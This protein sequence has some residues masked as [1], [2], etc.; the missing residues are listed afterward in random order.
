MKKSSLITVVLLIAVTAISVELSMA[1]ETKL[2]VS[3]DGNDAWSG[4]L[5]APNPDKTDGPFATL[6]GAR[7]AVRDLKVYNKLSSPVTVYI[8][9]GKYNLKR[10]FVL[11]A[12][13]SGTKE[14]PIIYSALADEEVIITGSKR[15]S[16][17][18]KTYRDNIM[19]CTIKDTQFEGLNFRQLFVNGERQIRARTP[20]E[21]FYHVNEIIPGEQSNS[22]FKY[23]KGDLKRWRNLTDVELIIFHSWDESRINIADINEEKNV[24]HLEYASHYPFDRWSG[25]YDGVLARYFVENVLEGLDSPGEWYFD[26]HSRELYY[27]PKAGENIHDLEITIPVINQLLLF[28]GDTLSGTPVSYISFSGITFAE[29]DCP[30]GWEGRWGDQVSPAGITFS[31]ASNCRLDK[32][33]VTNTGTYGIEILNGS[34]YNTIDKTEVSYTG[35]GGI[36]I[37]KDPSMRNTIS[38]NHVHHCGIIYPSGV[39][40]C[41]GITS[42]NVISHNHVHDIGY[43]G[44]TCRGAANTVEFNHVHH[45]MQRMCDGGGIYMYGEYS[46]GTVVRNN[47]FHDIIPYA[48]FG[49][50]IYL[51]ERSEYVTVQNNIVYR[52]QSGNTMM[53]GGR[54]NIWINNTFVDATKYQIFWNPL[55]NTASKN[56]YVNNIFYYTD[57]NTYLIHIAGQWYDDIILK[58]DYNLFYC[59]GGGPMKIDNMRSERFRTGKVLFEVKTFED[60]RRKGFDFNSIVADP[61]FVDSGNDNYTLREDSPMFELGFQ[62]IDISTVGPQE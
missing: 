17:S 28:Q 38:N 30:A 60:W 31:F 1:S 4:K 62:Q 11:E 51:D 36:R 58:S 55:R 41:V 53:H 16:G 56:I 34:K 26:R 46:D 22:S 54:N 2:F 50:G 5:L 57:P 24:V 44:L 47:V 33:T 15:V 19:V 23:R 21:G 27:W 12:K 49:W 8:R 48:Y 6:E 13:D 14:C 10:P 20:N 7:N 42:Q 25:H 45:V 39:G 40:I 18:W 37:D 32:C 52:T 43:C 9:G 3:K 29:S 61:L 59:A 35:S